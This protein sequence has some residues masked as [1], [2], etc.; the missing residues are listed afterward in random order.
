MPYQFV[1]EQ[2][3]WDQVISQ[4]SRIEH[5][6]GSEYFQKVTLT[7]APKY[8]C[9]SPSRQHVHHNSN[10]QEAAHEHTLLPLA[11]RCCCPH[12]PLHLNHWSQIQRSCCEAFCAVDQKI[13]HWQINCLVNGS[14]SHLEVSS[15]ENS[16]ES[17]GWESEWKMDRENHFKNWV[18]LL[19]Q[20]HTYRIE[21]L[22]PWFR[23][24]WVKVPF[25]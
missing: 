12:P 10:Q 4:K 9:N 24:L 8:M 7:A 25:H 11:P 20:S 21:S 13:T 1:T 22:A 6:T 2:C 15:L 18:Y 23:I 16:R 17:E 19:T 3:E 5:R 14:F